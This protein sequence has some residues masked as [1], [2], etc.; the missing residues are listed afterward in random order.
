M[1]SLISFSECVAP[2][3]RNCKRGLWI[4]KYFGTP[5]WCP[6]QSVWFIWFYCSIFGRMQIVGK[7]DN[8]WTRFLWCFL[9]ADKQKRPATCVAG[10]LVEISGIEPLTSWMPFKRSPKRY[11]YTPPWLVLGRCNKYDNTMEKFSWIVFLFGQL[12]WKTRRR[13]FDKKDTL[14]SELPQN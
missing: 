5:I 9:K 1:N 7:W 4:S 3:D 10:L 14:I 12:K 2:S 6:P 11:V 8:F 13:A